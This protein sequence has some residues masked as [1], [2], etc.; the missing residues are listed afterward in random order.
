[1]DFASITLL[2]AFAGACGGLTSAIVQDNLDNSYLI[3]LPF[4]LDKTGKQ[5]RLVP[6]GFLGNILIGA[7][8]AFQSFLSS[9][10]YLI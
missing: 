6:L 4:L 5:V 2:I 3:R 1:M 10:P 7:G 9:A 8:R